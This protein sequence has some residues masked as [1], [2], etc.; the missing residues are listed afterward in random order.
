MY[1]VYKFFKENNKFIHDLQ[2]L[3]VVIG[4]GSFIDV[5]LVGEN[6]KKK[7]VLLWVRVFY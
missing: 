3:K 1:N 7:T 6:Y 5:G 2:N 4:N